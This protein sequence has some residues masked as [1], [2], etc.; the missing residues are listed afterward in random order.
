MVSFRDGNFIVDSSTNDVL[1]MDLN[2]QGIVEL[3]KNGNDF[4]ELFPKTYQLYM[5]SCINGVAAGD[6]LYNVEGTIE[7]IILIVEQFITSKLAE[8]E[9]QVSTYIGD[10]IKE[11]CEV[12]IT[13]SADI[14]MP[15]PMRGNKAMSQYFI[16]TL[17][18]KVSGKITCFRN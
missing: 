6:V 8:D 17:N 9:R 15:I 10:A 1:I 5:E 14:S 18:N 12:Y 13:P 3:H 11:L 16:S 2:A 7:I 4:K